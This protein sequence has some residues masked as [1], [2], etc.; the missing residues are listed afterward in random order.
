MPQRRIC[1]ECLQT[2]AKPSC[3]FH[4]FQRLAC[5]QRRRHFRGVEDLPPAQHRQA[6]R[7]RLQ[8]I[9]AAYRDQ[10]TANERGIAGGIK[11]QQLTQR[12]AQQHSRTRFHVPALTA[13]NKPQPCCLNIR[14]RRR[15]PLR[16]PR[17]HHQQSIRHRLAQQ[18][19]RRQQN[20]LLTFVSTACHPDET[21]GGA[22]PL[23]MPA[24]AHGANS[25]RNC[26]FELE[27]PYR[28]ALRRQGSQFQVPR[29]VCSAL[30]E[31]RDTTTA[32]RRCKQTTQASIGGD[33]T[34]R[35]TR[36]R[37]CQWYAAAP[38]LGVKVRPDFG[39]QHHRTRGLHPV[40]KT[41]HGSG[42]IEWQKAVLDRLAE[43][44]CYA[45]RT[46]GG[47]GSH[48]QAPRGGLLQ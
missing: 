20:L 46:G 9:V 15:E 44:G 25:S 33:G 32:Q 8:Q 12:V 24:L 13:R 34:N 17:H 30:C 28:T 11:R 14:R 4:P 5:T 16:M 1:G 29:S 48:H 35:Q 26:Q 10:T 31:N 21:R 47:S 45:L 18:T 43:Q 37:E 3:V 19:V 41:R 36:T 40:Q 2:S 42:V 23:F 27:I 38:T 7:R 6:K 22:C 39:L